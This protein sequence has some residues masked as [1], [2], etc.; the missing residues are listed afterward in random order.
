MARS[1]PGVTFIDD[2]ENEIIVRGNPPVSLLWRLEGVPIPNPNHFSSI[3]SSSGA[4]SMLSSNTLSNSDFLT[5]AFPAEFGNSLSGVF[6]MHMRSGNSSKTE[7]TVMLGTLGIDLAREGPLKKGSSASYLVNYRYSTLALLDRAG[8]NPTQDQS[9]PDYQDLSFKLHLPTTRHG[10][11]NVFGLGGYNHSRTRFD[12][13]ATNDPDDYFEEKENSTLA[14]LGVNH[15]I[16]LSEKAYLK[17]TLAYSYYNIHFDLDRLP[18]LG[19][20]SRNTLELEDYDYLQSTLNLQYNQTFNAKHHLRMGLTAL[21]NQFELLYWEDRF[22]NSDSIYYIL[23]DSGSQAL[24]QSF[25]QWQYRPGPGLVFN[26]GFHQLYHNLNSAYSIEP[27][28][29]G[30]WQIN[31]RHQL[32]FGFGKHS[33]VGDI[34]T[35]FARRYAPQGAPVQPFRHLRIP[36]AWHYVLGYQYRLASDWHIK[37]ELYYQRLYDV[38]T[39]TNPAFPRQSIFNIANN[40]DILNAVSLDFGNDGKGR[41]LGLE[42]TLE[43]FFSDHYYLLFTTSLYDAR[44]RAISGEFYSTRFNGNY[45][46]NLLAGREWLLGGKDI[47][48]ANFK[49]IFADGNRYTPIDEEASKAAN[50]Q[51]LRFDEVYG[52]KTPRYFRLDV[53]LTYTLN[54][55]KMSHAFQLDV[56]NV[57]HIRNLSS[58]YYDR[59]SESVQKLLQTGI[60]PIFYY[61]MSF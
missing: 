32:S 13:R 55:K 45:I 51:I 37:T 22:D 46:F 40:Y 3:G 38:A 5:G 57:F 54:R 27:R 53:G 24:L 33:H 25:A 30:Q 47:L 49:V 23:D 21:H 7:N 18:G 11:F 39:S 43:K 59:N 31:S 2:L 9:Q 56:Q 10:V 52:E 29:S 15:L 50:R 36:K 16:P 48:S 20:P 17:T 12:F 19:N 60:I 8:L 34:T 4:I 58:Y 28:I 35:Y 6:D 26:L 41:N 61:K 1:F 14:L 42:I 44:Y